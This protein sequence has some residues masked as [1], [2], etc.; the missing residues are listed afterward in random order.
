[1]TL[2]I[3]KSHIWEKRNLS[4][5]ADS[6]T[7][8]F[9]SAGIQKGADSNFFLGGGGLPVVMMYG[10]RR[11]CSPATSFAPL[12]GRIAWEGNNNNTQ[13]TDIATL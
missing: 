6:S 9:V 7:D 13:R 3:K 1:M 5:D 10:G 12:G 11:L 2:C 8:I 4:T